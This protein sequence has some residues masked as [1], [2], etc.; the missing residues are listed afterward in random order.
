MQ[1]SFFFVPQSTRMGTF[2]HVLVKSRFIIVNIF[3]HFPLMFKFNKTP[4]QKVMRSEDMLFV[5]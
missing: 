2:S 3:F 1:L 5:F 4:A